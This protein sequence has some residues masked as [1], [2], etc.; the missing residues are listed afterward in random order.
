MNDYDIPQDV[1][2]PFSSW[3]MLLTVDM[4]ARSSSCSL[5]I[6]LAMDFKIHDS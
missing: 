5:F 2:Q 4:N 6:H 1:Q 3:S